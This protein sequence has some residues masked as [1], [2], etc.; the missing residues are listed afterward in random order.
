MITL[1]FNICQS[2]VLV[3][4]A[5]AGTVHVN[6]LL[7]PLYVQTVKLRVPPSLCAGVR[8]AVHE[9][10]LIVGRPP[11]KPSVMPMRSVADAAICEAV[12]RK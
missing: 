8:K 4:H 9:L 1:N 3:S 5:L 7:L 10:T 6:I 12:R 2:L 11:M